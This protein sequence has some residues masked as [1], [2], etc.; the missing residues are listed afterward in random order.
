MLP[1][2]P[3]VNVTSNKITTLEY[4]TSEVRMVLEGLQALSPEMGC[5]DTQHGEEGSQCNIH[6]M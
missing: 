6:I 5:V 3:K 4:L 1:L 2:P